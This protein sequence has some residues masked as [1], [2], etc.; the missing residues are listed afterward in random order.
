MATTTEASATPETAQEVRAKFNAFV[1]HSAYG[2]C[3]LDPSGTLL[4]VNPRLSE[5]LGFAAEELVGRHFS[6]LL[7]EGERAFAEASFGDAL[8]RPVDGPREYTI[9]GRDGRLRV[10]SVTSVP[11]VA[12]GC[13]RKLLMLLLDVTERRQAAEALRESE[14]RLHTITDAALDAIVMMDAEGK[15]A[16]WSAAAERMFG[17]HRR[18][19]LGRSIHQVLAPSRYRE[20]AGLGLDEFL[21]SGTG[22]VVG[23]IVELDGLRRDGTEFPVQL[24]VAPVRRDSHWWAV[25][26]IRDAT[27]RKQTE[28]VV[29]EEGRRFC[30]LLTAVSGYTYTVKMRRGF[31]VE[32]DHSWGCFTVTG[33]VP[34][35]YVA[36]PYL[37]IDMVHPE[38]RDPLRRYVERILACE[39]VSP[40]EHRIIRRDGAVRWVRDTIVPHHE[41]G[42]LV[43]YDGLVEDITDRRE[44]EAALRET[45][46]S[47]R[48][49]QE[50]QA[51][52]LPEKPPLLPGYDIAGASFPAMFTGGDYFDYLPMPDDS[53]GI[54]IGDVSGH[55]LGPALLMATLYAHL[56]SL[57]ESQQDVSEILARANRFLAK[58]TDRFITLFFGWLQ[59]TTRKFAYASAGHPTGYVFG[60]SGEVKME[61]ESTAIPLA[62]NADTDFP[63]GRSTVLEEGDVV[64]LLTDGILEAESPDERMFGVDRALETVRENLREPAEEILRRLLDTVA[65]Y[66]RPRKL[67]DDVTAIVIKVLR[68][69]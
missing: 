3:E 8:T 55:G 61:L 32:T 34:E 33:Y 64:F 30:D 23:K 7:D 42:S 4:W 9:C 53:L 63:M 43:R 38:D 58:E 18:E 31:P 13:P 28:E 41:N 24:S 40:I 1:E 69:G 25:A 60:A 50:I 17:Y 68:E 52:L 22:P 26:I 47:L 27:E 36:N 20:A 2:Y 66:S 16:Y 59:P 35:D 48:A 29:L 37:W 11:L 21:R 14:E 65:D 6:E 49:A 67:I 54:V 46:A 44:A 56:N 45:E 12:E 19:I 57:V 51:R 62:I 10:L 5:I 15:V 39:E